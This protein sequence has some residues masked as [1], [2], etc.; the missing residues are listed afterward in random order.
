MRLNSHLGFLK[1]FR[2]R[3]Q[4]WEHKRSSVHWLAGETR[5]TVKNLMCSL[6][7]MNQC[8]PD[9]LCLLEKDQNNT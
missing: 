1:G 9:M 6:H 7:I 2:W 4:S 8:I 5:Q 3:I